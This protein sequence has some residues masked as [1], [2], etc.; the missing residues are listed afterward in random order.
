MVF[1]SKRNKETLRLEIY[2]DYFDKEEENQGN[3][4]EITLANFP[5]K[6]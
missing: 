4:E 2:T 6:K 1:F 3:S 5:G